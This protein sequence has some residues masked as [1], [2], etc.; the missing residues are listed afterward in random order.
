MHHAVAAANQRI[1]PLSV[2]IVQWPNE[3]NIS[4]FRDDNVDGHPV[5]VVRLRA[6]SRRWALQALVRSANEVPCWACNGRNRGVLNTPIE[7][8]SRFFPLGSAELPGC[9]FPVDERPDDDE[10]NRTATAVPAIPTSTTVP[11][12]IPL[13]P[14]ARS[15]QAIHPSPT[16]PSEMRTTPM[17]P[18]PP[19]RS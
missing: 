18:I 19:P 8:D 15:V 16:V 11:R 5:A 1:K 17:A 3:I 10:R 6:R 14:A 13:A 7:S 12:A 9:Q 4:T 2:G